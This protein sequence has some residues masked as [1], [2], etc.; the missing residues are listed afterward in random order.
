MSCLAITFDGP[1]TKNGRRLF[2]SFVQANKYSFWNRSVSSVIIFVCIVLLSLLI[3]LTAH[4]YPEISSPQWTRWSSWVSCGHALCSYRDPSPIFTRCEP[5][6]L[7]E[8][9]NQ[10]MAT[11]SL[12]L[13]RNYFV[14]CGSAYVN[15]LFAMRFRTF[16]NTKNYSNRVTVALLSIGHLLNSCHR[17]WQCLSS[18]RYPPSRPCPRKTSP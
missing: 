17:H 6:G 5:L 2:E 18:C 1:K 7:V 8:C 13:V 16:T 11:R 4:H 3:L 14:T 9:W 10:P 12:H 15:L